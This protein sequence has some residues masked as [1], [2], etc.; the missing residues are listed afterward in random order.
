MIDRY[1]C[2]VKVD[3]REKKAFLPDSIKLKD[4]IERGREII[5]V[6]KM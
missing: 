6:N 1:L 5:L 4:I 2:K 3:D